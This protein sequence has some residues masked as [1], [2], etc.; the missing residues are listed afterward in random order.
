[1]LQN[2][3]NRNSCKDIVWFRLAMEE[4]NTTYCSNILDSDQKEL[5][6]SNLL[7]YQTEQ[8]MQEALETDTMDACEKLDTPRRLVCRENV[9]MQRVRTT[10]DPALCADF[11][12]ERLRDICK[13]ITVY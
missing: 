13:E 11:T 4:Y 8:I 9:L 3:K 1:M 5:C 7:S 2:E 6:E 10:R 12:T